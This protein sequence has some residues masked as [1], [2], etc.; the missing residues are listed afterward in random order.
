M[1]TPVTWQADPSRTLRLKK[2][3]TLP[4][5]PPSTLLFP[6]SYL[7]KNIQ[8]N[9]HEKSD[10][11]DKNQMWRKIFEWKTIFTKLPSTNYYFNQ[12]ELR[13]NK[14]IDETNEINAI[15]N[16]LLYIPFQVASSSC[17]TGACVCAK[18]EK[19]KMKCEKLTKLCNFFNGSW[20][21]VLIE[22]K[23]KV[24]NR[25]ISGRKI[26]IDNWSING[27]GR[28]FRIFVIHMLRVSWPV[29][30]DGWMDGFGMCR[31]GWQW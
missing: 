8:A 4:L 3:R 13:I 15:I 30:A 18:V 11:L 23:K 7:A 24:H 17:W 10:K 9:G 25:R 14:E 12:K 22:V 2:I 29:C 1:Y 31:C 20:K 6:S 19:V 21:V 27:S 28:T 16:Q 26:S 5:S